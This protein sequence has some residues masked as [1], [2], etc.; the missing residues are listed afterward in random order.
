[1]T[2][3][4]E[5]FRRDRNFRRRQTQTTQRP[6]GNRE[7]WEELEAREA[8]QLND[9]ILNAEC[10]DFFTDATRFVATIV[11]RVSSDR[12][13]EIT[14]TLRLEMETFLCDSIRHATNMIINLDWKRAKDATGEETFEPSLKNLDGKDLDGFRAEG[15]AQLGDKHFGQDPFGTELDGTVAQPAAQQPAPSVPVIAETSPTAPVEPTPDVTSQSPM[16][17][18]APPEPTDPHRIVLDCDDL[19]SSEITTNRMRLSEEELSVSFDDP[20]PSFEADEFDARISGVASISRTMS[21]FDSE[22]DMPLAA[23]VVE[24]GAEFETCPSSLEAPEV[25]EESDDDDEAQDAD[26]HDEVRD[27]LRL[28]VQEGIMTAEQARAAFRKQTV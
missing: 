1:M 3:D 21:N 12:Q 26:G 13:Q 20:D 22:D 25:A 18:Q 6:D 2:S 23:L 8:S 7:V 16:E 19:D 4:F 17:Y 14:E 11:Q 24:G 28:L 10:D 9:E 15:T 27:A 5:E